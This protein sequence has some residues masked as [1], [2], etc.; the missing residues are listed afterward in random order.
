[1]RSVRLASIK[2]LAMVLSRSTKGSGYLPVG[3]AVQV[4]Q[5]EGGCLLGR[6]PLHLSEQVGAQVPRAGIGGMGMAQAS[7]QFANLP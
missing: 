7:D 5:D 4:A 1:M 3:I 6:K 2:R